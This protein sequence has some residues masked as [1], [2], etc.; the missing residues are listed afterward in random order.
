MP[1]FIHLSKITEN[2]PGLVAVYNIQTG[3]YLHVNK[4]IKTLLG[5]E[6]RDFIVGGFKF[7]MSL[8]HPKD[9]KRLLAENM[10]ALE[11]VGKKPAK[12]G[13]KL[14]IVSF[15]YRMKHKNGNWVWLYTEGTIFSR[16]KKGTVKLLLSYSIDITK[17]KEKEVK[18]KTL[19]KELAALKESEHGFKNFIKVVEDYAIFRLDPEGRFVSWNEGVKSIFG[20]EEEEFLGHHLSMLC[21]P[22]DRKKGKEGV[23]LNDAIKFGS[24]TGEGLRARKDGTT[25]CGSVTITAIWSEDRKLMGFSKVIRD[26]TNQREAEETIR[27]QAFHDILTGLGNRQALS[28]HF[29]LAESVV[30]KNQL[31]IIFLDLDRFKNINDTL[32]HTIGD[33]VLKEVASRLKKAVRPIDTIA[34]LGGDEFIIILKN[35]KS[36]KEVLKHTDKIHASFAPIM[37]IKGYQLHITTSM[38]ISM[39]PLDGSDIY[40]LLKNADTALYRAKE[41]GRNRLQFYN[42]NMDVNSYAKLS[43]END[44]RLAIKK[45]EILFYYQPIVNSGRKL[46]GAEALMRWEHPKFGILSPGEFIGIAEDAGLIVPLG[47]ISKKI[48]CTQ[49]KKWKDKYKFNTRISLNISSKH[50]IETNF[51]K[52]MKLTLKNCKISPKDIELE[53]TESIA[54]NNAEQTTTKFADLRKLGVAI[55]IDD[56]GTGYSS[57]SYLKTF[58]INRLKIDKSFVNY[59]TTNNQD[60]SI[61]RAIIAVGHSLGLEIIAEGVETQEQ[62]DLLISEGCDG[63]QGYLFDKPLPPEEFTKW[64]VK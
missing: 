15:E 24:W 31:V 17:L 51:I 55:S 59:C 9:V 26:V 39:F 47:N 61:I 18:V 60:S 63:F 25:F 22:A 1:S 2:F 7:V 40:S 19:N 36:K 54:M 4:A 12:G 58:P 34:R 30:G 29:A 14:P 20:Y 23:I 48:I 16:D 49:Y 5:Y 57:L 56:F 43:L 53:I 3:K 45:D 13:D 21:T 8:I 37:N 46:I 27:Y 42:H 35:V 44:L 28:E 38:G 50:F 33:E 11:K 64:L 32:G 52:D 10:E 62:F 41:A 6:P